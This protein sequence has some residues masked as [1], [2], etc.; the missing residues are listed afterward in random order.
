MSDPNITEIVRD[1]Y[2]KAA[3]RVT[4]SEGGCCSTASSRSGCDPITS[5][6]YGSDEVGVNARWSDACLARMREPDRARGAPARGGRAG[7]RLR[8]GHRRPALRS[9][10][11]AHRA[12]P[13]GST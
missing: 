7:P 2:A 1:K 13:T 8:R 5:N 10:A 3:L 9:A 6:L 11:S 12:R 4:N